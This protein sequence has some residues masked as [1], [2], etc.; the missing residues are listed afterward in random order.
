MV[1]IWVKEE[2]GFEALK[3]KLLLFIIRKFQCIFFVHY[4]VLFN[5]IFFEQKIITHFFT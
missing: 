3:Q 1:Y 4:N 5:Y 2:K